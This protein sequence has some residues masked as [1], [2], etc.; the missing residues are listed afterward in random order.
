MTTQTHDSHKLLKFLLK[1]S[2][3]DW[4]AATEAVQNAYLAALK[5]YHTFRHKSSYFTWLCRIGLN[6]LADYYKKQINKKSKVLIPSI[7]IFN[8]IFDPNLSIEETISLN[9]LTTAMSKCIDLLPNRYKKLV[10]LKYYEQLS[11]S[12]IK[13]KFHLTTRSL[14]GKLYRAKQALKKIIT[15]KNPELVLEYEKSSTD[16]T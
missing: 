3:G 9:E 8:N 16:N 15:Q 12:Q 10:Q 2:G 7:E 13:L 6:K 11:N 5:S 4:E 1:K 14:E